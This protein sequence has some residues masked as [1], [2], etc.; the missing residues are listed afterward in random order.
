MTDPLGRM[1][2]FSYL[3]GLFITQDLSIKQVLVILFSTNPDPGQASR[4]SGVTWVS[5]NPDARPPL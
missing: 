1:T 2:L 5:T 4:E 3:A